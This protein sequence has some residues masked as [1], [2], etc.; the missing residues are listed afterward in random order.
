MVIRNAML[1]GPKAELPSLPS[2]LR[3]FLSSLPSILSS[4][5]CVLVHDVLRGYRFPQCFRVFWHIIIRERRPR[6]AQESSPHPTPFRYGNDGELEV[7]QRRTLR[8]QTTR[9][10]ALPL[11]SFR[12]LLKKLTSFSGYPYQDSSA[13]HRGPQALREAHPPVHFQ[14][15]LLSLLPLASCNEHPPHRLQIPAAIY[16]LTH[17]A[18]EPRTQFTNDAKTT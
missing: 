8:A 3:V 2:L 1:D 6:E 17:S 16:S 18:V 5:G 9:L 15:H 12:A 14:H 4:T 7:Q 11:H 10:A 13:K